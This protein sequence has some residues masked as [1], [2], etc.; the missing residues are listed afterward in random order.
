MKESEGWDWSKS[1]LTSDVEITSEDLSE[2]DSSEEE[3]ESE[4]DSENSDDESDSDPDSDDDT[5]SGGGHAFGRV[6]YE[7]VSS[8]GQTSGGGNSENSV[9]RQGP[10]DTVPRSSGEL[11]EQFQRPQRIRTIPRRY[12][13]SNKGRKSEEANIARGDLDDEPVLLMASESDRRCLSDWWYMDT[14]GIGNV[15][16]K[17]KN[18][19]NVPIKDVCTGAYKLYCPETNRVEVSRDVIMKESEGWDWSKSKLTSDVEITSEDLSE[20]DSSEEESESEDDSE[21]S[22]DESDSDPDSDD[23]TESGGG[24]AF[25]R[26]YSEDVSS[27]GQTSG[28]GNSENSVSRQGPEDTVPRSSGELSEQ[29]QRPQRIRTIPRSRK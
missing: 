22:D 2:V 11:S 20:V 13:W 4:D 24:H 12:C 3:S 16:V 25:G 10:E 7:D 14:E 26:L 27:G 5:E 17:V 21:N 6:Y 19:K 8:G 1:K 18:G 23:D 15:K 29:F 9:S 28:G